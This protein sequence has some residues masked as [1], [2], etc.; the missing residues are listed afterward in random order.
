[1][2]RRRGGVRGEVRNMYMHVSE[3][4]SLLLQCVPPQTYVAR[5]NV[6]LTVIPAFIL[7]THTIHCKCSTRTVC[8]YT[9]T[10]TVWT[11]ITK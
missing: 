3:V 6:H 5:C 9:R 1:M 11:P 10:Y 8:T 7:Y 2:E 4:V